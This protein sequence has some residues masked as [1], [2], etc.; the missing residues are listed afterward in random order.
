MRTD[1]A[2]EPDEA[3]LAFDGRPAA[4]IIAPLGCPANPLGAGALQAK[5]RALAGAAL[6]GAVDDPRRPARDV[7][8]A[9]AAVE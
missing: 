6:E 7:L 5:V 4:H 3:L 9:I 2:F 1:A 8:A